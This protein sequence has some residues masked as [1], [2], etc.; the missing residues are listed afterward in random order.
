MKQ[1]LIITFE[2]KEKLKEFKESITMDLS[3]DVDTG[4]IDIKEIVEW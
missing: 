3:H 1:K 2:T 4:I